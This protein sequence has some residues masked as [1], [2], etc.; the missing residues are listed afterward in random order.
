M[1]Q[2]KN[3]YEDDLGRGFEFPRLKSN[4]EIQKPKH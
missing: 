2:L 3:Y 1:A 4:Y